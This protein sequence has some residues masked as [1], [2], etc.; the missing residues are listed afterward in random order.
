GPARLDLGAVASTQ[1]PRDRRRRSANLGPAYERVGGGR[2]LLQSAALNHDDY[3][4]GW[5]KSTISPKL[6]AHAPCR[7]AGAKAAAEPQASHRGGRAGSRGGSRSP[8]GGAFAV[9]ASLLFGGG[10]IRLLPRGARAVSGASPRS[11]GRGLHRSGARDVRAW[12]GAGFGVRHRRDLVRATDRGERRARHAPSFRARTRD[13]G[14]VGT[15]PG[16]SAGGAT[17]PAPRRFECS[18]AGAVSAGAG[19][20]RGAT[21]RRH[22]ALGPR[23]RFRSRRVPLD[24]ASGALAGSLALRRAGHAGCSAE[25]R[26]RCPDRAA[27]PAQSAPRGG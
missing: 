1:R 12:Y 20:Q 10:R 14:T 6:P 25:T 26:P 8:P 4:T 17:R 18:G 3:P 22:L 24:A 13:T 9:P 16:Q 19:G 27:R 7:G 2:S 11:E 23:R 5:N 21:T 15:Y